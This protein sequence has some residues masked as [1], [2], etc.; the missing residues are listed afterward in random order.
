M[1]HKVIQIIILALLLTSTISLMFT[2]RIVIAGDTI[3]IRANGLVDPPT[4]PIS[5]SG[6]VYTFTANIYESIVIEKDNIIVNG[7]GY[8]LQGTPPSYGFTLN[9]R[10]NVTIKK[11]YITGFRYG[12]YLK[13]ST[14]STIDSNALINCDRGG[15]WLESS[16]RINIVNNAMANNYVGVLLTWSNNTNTI[17][18]NSIRNNPFGVMLI[19]SS[20]NIIKDNTIANNNLGGIYLD[21]ANNSIIYHN[22]LINNTPQA[23]TPD[24]VDTW[25]NGYPSGGNYWSDYTGV[26]LKS[27][28]NQ[29]QPGSDGIGDTQYTIDTNNK[30][31][32]PL[33]SIRGIHDMAVTNVVISKTVIGQGK[34]AT[35]N[36]TVQNQGSLTQ[37][38]DVKV[39][40]NTS[41]IQTL[42]LYLTNGSSTTRT[43]TW[44]TTGWTKG[45]Y[46]LRASVT[47]VPGETDTADNTFVYGIIKVT[48]PG[49]VDGDRDIDIYDIV[50]IASAYGAKR[51]ETRFNPNCDIDSNDIIYIYDVVIATS[52][53]GYKE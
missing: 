53:Y 25:D 27:G 30:D 20:N 14:D 46:T 48:V 26:D 8:T 23:V 40:A 2:T 43:I 39:Y 5:Q 34:S 47:I 51:G 45:T 24:S 42:S 11:T 32:Y 12:I 21:R 52:S 6:N 28:P 36:A 37:I 35:I 38:F 10:S 44:N 19:V 3:Y 17:A 49:D 41:I 13:F 4:A 31:R 22:N 16:T 29:D 15:I 1:K 50:R 7:N 33:M 18:S 9:S